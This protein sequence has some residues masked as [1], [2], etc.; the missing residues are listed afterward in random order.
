MINKKHLCCTI[1]LTC[2]HCDLCPIDNDKPSEHVCILSDS[3][4]VYPFTRNAPNAYSYYV[5]QG[6]EHT[7]VKTCEGSTVDLEIRVDFFQNDFNSVKAAIIFEGETV[8]IN[9]DLS[10]EHNNSQRILVN[11]PDMDNTVVVSIPEIGLT[12]YRRSTDL[13]VTFA[14]DDIQLS[15]LC[16]NLGEEL[17]FPDCITT[18]DTN[19][20]KELQ[21][22]IRSYKIKPS[23]QILRGERKECGKYQ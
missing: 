21:K 17:V 8:I 9:E 22:F 7:L 1:I 19:D 13:T 2:L 20:Y 11:Q 16:G 3:K 23:D 5:G 18:L 14:E 4:R 15:G 6:C 12:V 10:L